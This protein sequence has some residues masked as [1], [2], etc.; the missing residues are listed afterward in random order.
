[1]ILLW[2][3]GTSRFCWLML[4]LGNDPWC[5]HCIDHPTSWNSKAMDN[6]SHLAVCIKRSEEKRQQDKLS[7]MSQLQY[8]VLVFVSSQGSDAGFTSLGVFSLEKEI[9]LCVTSDVWSDVRRGFRNTTKFLGLDT[10][11]KY[12][13]REKKLNGFRK[14]KF[15]TINLT[16]TWSKFDENR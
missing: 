11:L 15:E 1:M 14:F 9:F 3:G 7:S 12:I 8:K 13:L 5:V 16:E 10:R 6:D 2:D 4:G